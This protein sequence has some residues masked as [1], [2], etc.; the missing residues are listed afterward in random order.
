RWHFFVGLQ[1]RDPHPL[2]GRLWSNEAYGV[3]D[4][5]KG[6]RWLECQMLEVGKSAKTLQD[7][8]EPT[9]LGLQHVDD[10]VHRRARIAIRQAF[11]QKLNVDAESGQRV[12]DL[13]MQS[14]CQCRHTE[15]SFHPANPV[16]EEHPL[17]NVAKMDDTTHG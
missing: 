17:R 7:A 10:F 5:P 9:D 4:N 3:L 13:V 1:K 12:L 11:L 14:G 15:E 16:F 6:I 8:V 2:L